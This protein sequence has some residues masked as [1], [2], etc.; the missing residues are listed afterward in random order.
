MGYINGVLRPGIK[1]YK[2]DYCIQKSTIGG[3]RLHTDNTC[4]RCVSLS[5]WNMTVSVQSLAS[6][7]FL[8]RCVIHRKSNMVFKIIP[9]D[10]KQPGFFWWG[11]VRGWGFICQLYMVPVSG[12]QRYSKCWFRIL[13]SGWSLQYPNLLFSRIHCEISKPVFQVFKWML[14]I[15]LNHCSQSGGIRIC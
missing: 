8:N 1:D 7:L 9:S 12:W 13:E 15:I 6:N 10:R 11:G 14:H 2:Y 3:L 4:R 5:G